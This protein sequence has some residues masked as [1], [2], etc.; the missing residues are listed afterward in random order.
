MAFPPDNA[1]FAFLARFFALV[2]ENFCQSVTVAGIACLPAMAL[3]RLLSAAP[4]C[5]HALLRNAWS[6]AVGILCG[7]PVLLQL[8]VWS[9]IV[10]RALH[11]APTVWHVA[12]AITCHGAAHIAGCIG[13]V[14][15]QIYATTR[16][17]TDLVGQAVRILRAS[18]F[19]PAIPL[20]AT[21]TTGTADASMNVTVVAACA[22]ACFNGLLIHAA[23]SS[24]T[25][26]LTTPQ[27]AD[28]TA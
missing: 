27:R 15:R 6:V 4:R 21:L 18:C 25:T 17:R 23:T 7:I 5:P 10:P 16:P 8:V 1:A 2:L 26:T 24:L 9:F 11:D 13:V 22:A 19:V 3:G 14:G 28:H 20:I 12:A